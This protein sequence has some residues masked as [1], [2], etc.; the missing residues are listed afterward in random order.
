MKTAVY[1]TSLLLLASAMA[2]A[3]DA[4]TAPLHRIHPQTAQDLQAVLAFKGH[5]LPFVSAHR[6][7]PDKGFPENCIPTFE[8]TLQHTFSML[9]IDPRRTKDG[10]IVVLHDATLE[11]TTTGTGKL[12]DFTLA[13]LKK[14]HLKDTG[15]QATAFRMP[16][17]DEVIEWARGKTILVL[18]QKDVTPIERAEIVTRHKAEAYVMLIVSSFKDAVA[19]HKLNPDILMEVMIPTVAKAEE[20]DRLGIP[21]RNVIAFVGHTPPQEVA[22]YDFIHR[23][24]ACCMAGTSRHLDLKVI[25]GEVADIQE[26]EEGYR[27]FLSLGADIFETD[28]PVRL[29]PM[30]HK[31]EIALKQ[32]FFE[33][34]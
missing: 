3:Q 29:G 34:K 2:D 25:R 12:A 14:L 27:S 33:L 9:E 31:D 8:H 1:L 20:F 23:K 32:P 18:D 16:T 30:L 11:R 22:L 21:W 17:L 6:G 19:V 26:I 24:G 10:A 4:A 7:G 28:I 13:E 15:G 5:H